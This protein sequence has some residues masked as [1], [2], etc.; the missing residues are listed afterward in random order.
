MAEELE[1]PGF[2]PIEAE[3]RLLERGAL[4]V[5]RIER[6]VD[7]DREL[8]V[9]HWRVVSKLLLLLELGFLL[10]LPRAHSLSR[11]LPKV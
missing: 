1:E 10:S 7:R 6:G 11:D 8:L 3:L 4:A 2:E 9:R 5:D